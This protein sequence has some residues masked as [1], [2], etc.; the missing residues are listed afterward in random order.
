MLRKTLLQVPPSELQS[1]GNLLTEKQL[2]KRLGTI[3]A[4]KLYELRNQ[5]LIPVVKLG[6]RTLRYNEA[7]V[8]KAINRLTL[9]E[10]EP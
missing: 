9:K 1:P 8:R 6:H 5:R 2:L 3:S 7:A 10:V 4:K